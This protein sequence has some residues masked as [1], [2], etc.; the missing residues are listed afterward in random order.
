MP[1][2]LTAVDVAVEHPFHSGTVAEATQV[3]VRDHGN[4]THWQGS[5]ADYAAGLAP[6][7]RIPTRLVATKLGRRSGCYSEILAAFADVPAPK[8]WGE[9]L[10]SLGIG[11]DDELPPDL[12]PHV[13][14]ALEKILA[15]QL[16]RN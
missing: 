12:V 6:E 5:A 10:A 13:R 7:Y 16:P 14:V 9:L 2:T 15:R 11:P 8:N 4:N 3:A 1:S